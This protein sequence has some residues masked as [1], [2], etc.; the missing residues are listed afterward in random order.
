MKL[1]ITGTPG[2]GKTSLARELA[3]RENWPL[4]EV[5][6]LVSQLGCYKRVG[7][8]KEVDLRV[9]Q[10][11]LKKILSK[12]KNAVVE[13]HLLC[14]FN[15]PADKVSVL[16]ANPKALVSR[17]EK[18]GYSKQKIDENLFSEFLDYC[19]IK[20]ERNYPKNKVLQ[21]DCSK[22]ISAKN[23]FKK[24]SA[25]KIDWT[26]LLLSKKFGYLLKQR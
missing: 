23:F 15:L 20:A 4:V 17:L 9:L 14:E 3:A 21:L 13:G 2:V 7:G 11:A 1:I 16:R 19:L 26:P 12:Q 6:E 25:K 22:K 8:E 10:S 5:N 24:L 18:R